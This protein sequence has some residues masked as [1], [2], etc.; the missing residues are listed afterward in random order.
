VT[1]QVRVEALRAFVHGP[2]ALTAATEAKLEEWRVPLTTSA[3]REEALRAFVHRFDDYPLDA[4]TAA[5][6]NPDLHPRGNDGKFIE[7]FGLIDLIDMPGFRHGQRGS[8]KVQGEVAEIIPDSD[9]PGNPIIRVKMTDPRWDAAAFGGTF[10]ARSY[11]ISSRESPKAT[12]SWE[13]ELLPEGEAPTIAPPA[14]ISAP[15]HTPASTEV[16]EIL[17]PMVKTPDWDSFSPETKH[18]WMKAQMEADLAAFRGAP[19]IWNLEGTD[20]E[21]G[22]RLANQYRELT[23]VDPATALWVDAVVTNKTADTVGDELVKP[24]SAIAVAYPGTKHPGGIGPITN[25]K[26]IVLNQAHFQDNKT[27]DKEKAMSIGGSLPWSAGGGDPTATLVHEFGHHRQFRYLA[28]TMLEAGQPFS[29]VRQ[30]DGFGLMP[31]SS[32]WPEVQSARYDIQKLAPSQYGL[33][34]SSEAFAE[35]WS[36]MHKGYVPIS[37]DLQ[38]AWDTWHMGMDIPDQMPNSRFTPDELVDYESLTPVEQEAYWAEVGSLLDIP[39]MREHYPETAALYDS[40]STAEMR[41]QPTITQFPEGTLVEFRTKGRQALGYV[42][43]M[44]DVER[45]EDAML[46]LQSGNEVIPRRV[47]NVEPFRPPTP[48]DDRLSLSEWF[49][50]GREIWSEAAMQLPPDQWNTLDTEGNVWSMHSGTDRYMIL[51]WGGEWVLY[52]NGVRERTGSSAEELQQGIVAPQEVGAPVPFENER[53]LGNGLVMR[54]SDSSEGRG[55]ITVHAPDGEHVGTLH[56]NLG[57]VSYLG[58]RPEFQRQG[59]ATSMY[60]WARELDPD[61]LHGMVVSESARSWIDT[62]NPDEREQVGRPET[63]Y[64]P[65]L[66][67]ERPKVQEIKVSNFEQVEAFIQEAEKTQGGA[68]SFFPTFGSVD[69]V[70]ADSPSL[71]P[72]DYYNPSRN[73]IFYKG[74]WQTFSPA[75]IIREQNRGMGSD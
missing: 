15:A 69:I 50:G 72:D 33:S 68:W 55:T 56:W 30:P 40:W 31:D 12:I 47:R 51:N 45:G 29:K 66:M 7:T 41:Q 67:A 59:I 73:R 20:P 49:Q 22:F 1:N 32:N 18:A 34:K 70:R 60:R 35:V 75:A 4:I 38:M 65:A 19:T 42:I 54:L 28:S 27:W 21:V 62:L 37:P 6:W 36:A 5:D 24:T 14:P 44:D 53:K 26:A 61:L 10:D 52:K 71:I 8:K 25:R 48:D 9:D 17:P 43:G 57:G 46:F 13:K 63:K 11:Q 74:R 39:G 64:E 3:V 58:V 16:G 2:S 23:G